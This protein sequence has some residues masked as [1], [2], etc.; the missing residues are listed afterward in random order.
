MSVENVEPGPSETIR[1]AVIEVT[2]E[3]PGIP[4][5]DREAIFERFRQLEGSKRSGVGLGLAI[6][7]QI[8]HAH[9]G[10]LSVHANE[11][12]G[13]TFSLMLPVDHGAS[14]ADSLEE[15]S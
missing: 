2:D 8:A 6:S 7:R 12:G 4:E 3:G 15:I 9:N 11:N 1:S 14:G 5:E 10:S 13:S